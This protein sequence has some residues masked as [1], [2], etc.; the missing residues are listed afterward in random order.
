MFRNILAGTD[1]SD[2]AMLAVHHAVDLADRIG[3]D[4]TVL[5]V[6]RHSPSTTGDVGATGPDD[7]VIAGA[8]L[9]DVETAFGGR[10]AI[11]TRFEEGN[12][13]QVLL[14]V[15]QNDHHDL[16]VVGNRGLSGE[17]M[18]QPSSVPGRVSRRA[19]AAVLVV[20]TVAGRPPGYRSILV[21]TDG[22]PT[23][24]TA[25]AA[26]VELGTALGARVDLATAG[27]SDR[28]AGR[29]A[30]DARGRRPNLAIHA[31]RGEPSEALCK[32]AESDSYDLLVLGNRGMTGLRRSLR[33][34]PIRVLRKAPTN[35]LIVH[36][37]G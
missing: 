15:A 34:V 26:A 16:L 9:R 18:L 8:L 36:T 7:P 22:S 13:A 35:V 4:L 14:E 32:L 29:L 11:R 10:V 31:V 25:E 3:A 37:T 1:G 2:T 28:E 33:S 6:H 24:T 12:P 5:T 19:P 27:S 21:G 30:E 20:D 23:A 17:A